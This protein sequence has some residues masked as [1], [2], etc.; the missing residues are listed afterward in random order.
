MTD[1]KDTRG[2][3]LFRL[4][5]FLTALA[6]VGTLFYHLT[7]T[8]AWLADALPSDTAPLPFSAVVLDAGHG[9][10]D[11]G[12]QSTDG[13]L[14][15]ELNLNITLLLADL[16][17]MQGTT[18]VLTRSDDRLLY[19]PSSDYQGHKK[20]QDLAARL[21]IAQEMPDS[22]F[23]SIHMNAFPQTQYHGLQVWY[24]PHHERSAGLA[25]SV[26]S[27]VRT[28]LQ[29]Q[30]ARRT[31]AATSN[32]YLLDRLQSPA[33]LVECGFLSNAEEATK[34]SNTDY[35]QTLAL[36]IFL[37]AFSCGE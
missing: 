6:T 10:E 37:S 7:P 25:Q 8:P 32:I 36:L 3:P 17:A 19:D 18:V 23:I 2:F 20:E 26:Q 35:Q 15:K 22:L 30:N 16:F 4:I 13:I 9:G 34:L 28:Y 33:I 11:G 31:K 14:E 21:K 1:A 24:S 27:T 12:A 5:L 29:P